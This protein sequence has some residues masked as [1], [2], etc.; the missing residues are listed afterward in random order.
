MSRLLVFTIVLFR[1]TM[2]LYS[3]PIPIA[4]SVCLSVFCLSVLWPSVAI[5]A[6]SMYGS[7]IGMW[8]QFSVSID[9]PRSRPTL[10]PNVGLN[11]LVTV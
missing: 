9:V 2:L 10:I 3:R 7:R 8:A 1:P 4:T 5:C 6:Y 11:R